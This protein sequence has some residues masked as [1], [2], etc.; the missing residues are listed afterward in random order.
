MFLTIILLIIIAVE[1]VFS[2]RL[3]Y[4]N[5]GNL[6]LWYGRKFRNYIKIF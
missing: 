2:P 3:D 1:V 5:E 6:L 4:T